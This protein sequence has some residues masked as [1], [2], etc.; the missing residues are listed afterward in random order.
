MRV[1]SLSRRPV[2]LWNYGAEKPARHARPGRAALRRARGHNGQP[3]PPRLLALASLAFT[4][5][6]A[7]TGEEVSRS[8]RLEAGPGRDASYHDNGAET[9]AKNGFARKK[10]ASERGGK[11]GL[12][13]PWRSGVGRGWAARL[14]KGSGLNFLTA[15]HRAV[16][17]FCRPGEENKQGAG[18]QFRG[19]K[20]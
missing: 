9:V 12:T 17:L 7:R 6:F 8:P 1:S 20:D 5:P 10:Q 13:P 19:L 15:W 2:P 4:P 18:K 14:A 3:P 16:G 11:S